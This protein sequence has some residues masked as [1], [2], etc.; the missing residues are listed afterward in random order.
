MNTDFKNIIKK[1][2][3]KKLLNEISKTYLYY[4]MRG[5]YSNFDEIKK[6]V[7]N[8]DDDI[9]LQRV[10]NA[11]LKS[12]KSKYI[13]DRDGEIIY[14][15]EFE[16]K[17]IKYLNQLNKKKTSY[18]IDFGGSLMNFQRTHSL[19]INKNITWI[20]IE[21]KKICQLGKSFKIKANFFENLEKGLKHI[22][23][24]NI[25]STTV[26]FGSVL[27]YVENIEDIIK[28]C[29]KNNIGKIIIHRQPILNKLEKKISIQHV[30]FWISN[31]KYS[32]CLYKERKLINYF[33]KHNYKLVDSFKSI[34]Y[35]YKDGQYK[36]FIFIK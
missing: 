12:N 31:L 22:G 1:L 18:V 4:S 19:I 30:P 34:G 10:K 36:N 15:K 23:K 11:Y 9:I 8:Y 5:N 29:S 2:I 26:L 24:K 6:K 35:R 25:K 28:I 32:V 17:I 16:F 7:T 3:P 20:V 21:N 13:Y 27:Q 33:N 14:K